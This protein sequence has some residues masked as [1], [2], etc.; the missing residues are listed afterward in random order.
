MKQYRFHADPGHG[1]LEVPVAELAALGIADKVSGYSYLSRDGK[2]AYLEEDCDATVFVA[3][4]APGGIEARCA[5]F[6]MNTEHVHHDRVGDPECFIRNL[7]SY[8][9]RS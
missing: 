3:A 8:G 1:W 6:S 9:V 7:P 5:W 2:T 4:K